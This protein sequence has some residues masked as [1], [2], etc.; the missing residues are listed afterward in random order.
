VSSHLNAHATGRDVDMYMK[1]F[2]ALADESRLRA[3]PPDPMITS[4]LATRIPDE[5]S[6]QNSQHRS[7]G[8]VAPVGSP[9]VRPAG[10]KGRTHGRRS[11][12]RCYVSALVSHGAA[13]PPAVRRG[14]ARRGPRSDGR[15]TTFRSG[16]V[17]AVARLC[18]GFMISVVPDDQSS[19]AGV[20]CASW[21]RA[22]VDGP[23][24]VARAD[25]DGWFEPVLLRELAQCS[26]QHGALGTGRVSTRPA[27]LTW[28]GLPAL[29]PASPCRPSPGRAGPAATGAKSCGRGVGRDLGR[30]RGLGPDTG[31]RIGLLGETRSTP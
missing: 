21:G 11:T 2:L 19:Q 15:D 5:P 4:A 29:L 24:P 17:S 22:V 14:R 8:G 12:T 25:P 27:V 7:H 1:T 31:G 3:P 13:N 28:P 26:P 18:S 16:T 9:S 6:A 30:G 23:E 20:G 10:P